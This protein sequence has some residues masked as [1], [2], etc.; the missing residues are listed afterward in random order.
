MFD[1]FQLAKDVFWNHVL[2]EA[3]KKNYCMQWK[4]KKQSWGE[5]RFF[6]SNLIS[7]SCAFLDWKRFFFFSC[8]LCSWLKDIY[9][10][11]FY[12]L[13]EI[14]L[15]CFRWFMVFTLNQRILYTS[16]A[17][18]ILFV[19][20]CITMNRF[21]GKRLMLSRDRRGFIIICFCSFF[22]S[23][24]LNADKFELINVSIL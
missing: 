2:R 21:I 7:R 10:L 24:R 14:L 5:M 1:W 13:V 16:E 8:L 15:F 20:Y 17:S 4:R 22:S 6:F 23:Q 3:K 11:W 19:Y 18:T 12:W 9:L